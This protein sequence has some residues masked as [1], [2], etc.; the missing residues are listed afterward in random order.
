[1]VEYSDN[2]ADSSGNLWQFKRDEQNMTD[3][4][5]LKN[6]TTNDS[7]F[8]KYKSSLLGESAADGDNKKFKDVKIVVPLK[9]LSKIFRSKLYVPIVTL[10]ANNVPYNENLTKQLNEGFK[11]HVY[12]KIETQEAN[13]NNPKRFPYD[14]SFQ[15]VD[16]LLVL[17]FN[18]TDGANRVQ[19]NSHR[20]Y[21]LPRVNITNGNV[22]IDGKNFYDQPISDQIRKYD[23]I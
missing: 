16:R 7:S 22:L 14:A 4:G 12:S 10:S 5:N 15:G 3:A 1:M 20:K 2:Y 9:Y 18:N 8:L 23:E 19:R 6:V 17:A 11:R 13:A 21:F